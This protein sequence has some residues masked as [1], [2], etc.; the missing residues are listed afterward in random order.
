[1]KKSAYDLIVVGGGP[2]G[3]TLATLV[4]KHA[5]SR[6]VLLL[7]K[8]TGPRHHIGESL[9]PGM[10]PVLKEL[11]V[12]E[13]ID[14]AGFPRKIGAN[15]VW[16]ADRKVWENDFN[17]INVQ[18]MIDR[19]GVLPKNLQYAW[20]VRRSRYD[21]ILLQHAEESGVEVR[22]GWTAKAAVEKDGR[23]T[24]IK[25]LGP[26]GKAE[27]LEASWTA[28]CS[29]Q[30]AFLSR[31]RKV[32]RFNTALRNVA[33][34]AYFK[35]AKWK[36]TYTGHPEKTKIFISSAKDGWL[37]YIPIDDGIISVGL[38]TPAD[39]VEGSS[40]KALE[41]ALLKELKACEE[42]WPLIEGAEIVA[43]FDGADQK[44]FVHSDWSYLSLKACGPGW[45]ACGDSAVFV[46]PILSTGVTLAHIGAHRAAYS[47]L[48]AWEDPGMESLL[49]ED[50]NRFC[51]E[52]AAGY[53][54]MALFWYGNDRNAKSWWARAKEIQRAWFPVEMTDKQAFVTV[55]AGVTQQFDRVVSADELLQEQVSRPS[56]FPF[57]TMVMRGARAPA[58]TRPAARPR[59]SCRYEVET[60]FVAVAGSG[61]LR[62]VKRIRFL[63]HDGSDPIED[64]L[65][66]RKPVHRW[67]LELLPLLD[68][69]RTW[70]GIET[71]LLEKGVPEWWAKGPARLFVQD[72]ALQGVL[73]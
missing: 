8:A 64:A 40:Q 58:E 9:L 16:G 66:P 38:V 68:G 53:L 46:D 26:R 35:G 39:K 17:E 59:L 41:K 2:A 11:G 63:K 43:G 3:T 45:M 67:H 70:T 56:E 65:N 50:Y 19:F 14:S 60:T 47:L 18:D 42:L 55:A 7:E 61:R 13:K 62:P 32:R 24:G 71:G 30:A 27:T 4:K 21:E 34:Y 57:Y 33:V 51:R 48:T 1:M 69:G 25:A 49:L 28:D 15:Y 22:R 29:G 52:S 36:Y 10:A 5:P 54:V 31:Y 72:L 73:A 12:Y 37:W 6:K 20:Q 44:F 23:I